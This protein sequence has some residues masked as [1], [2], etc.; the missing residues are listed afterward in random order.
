M[1]EASVDEDCDP[2]VLED[3]V[4][5]N[6]ERAAYRGWRIGV[7]DARVDA[8]L[9]VATPP[10]D[11]SSPELTDQRQLGRLVATFAHTGRDG[12]PSGCMLRVSSQRDTT[13]LAQLH[14]WH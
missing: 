14:A 11:A 1:P 12:R 9:D 4:W 3:K 8:N 10:L 13:H 2:F 6:Y 7:G 5:S